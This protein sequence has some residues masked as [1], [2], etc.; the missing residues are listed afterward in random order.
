MSELNKRISIF[1]VG[2]KIFTSLCP[3]LIVFGYIEFIFHPAFIFPLNYY[4]MVIIGSILLAFGIFMFVYSER[5][6]SSAY[7]SSSLATSK[8]YVYIRHPMYASWGYGSLPG[9]FCFLNSWIFLLNLIA[10]YLIF[11]IFI[12]EEEKYLLKEFGKDYEHYRKNVNAI[13]PKLSK[14]NP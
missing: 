5:V 8:I 10:Y 13:F 4:W 1:G 2:P 11:K 14:Y 6:M 3:F 12:K 9:I 7:N